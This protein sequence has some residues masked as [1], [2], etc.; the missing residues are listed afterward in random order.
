MRAHTQHPARGRKNAH[1]IARVRT[2]I[3]SSNED[4]PRPFEMFSD[5]LDESAEY[6]RIIRDFV[7]VHDAVLAADEYDS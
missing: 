5:R 7:S 2:D 1:R 6:E 3:P 4:E